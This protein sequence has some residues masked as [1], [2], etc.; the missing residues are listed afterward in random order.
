M[1]YLTSMTR[2]VRTIMHAMVKTLLQSEIVQSVLHTEDMFRML[3]YVT[4]QTQQL[5]SQLDIHMDRLVDRRFKSLDENVRLVSIAIDRLTK[6]VET[7][8]QT[9]VTVTD[10]ITASILTISEKLRTGPDFV[11]MEKLVYRMTRETTH[12]STI[13]TECHAHSKYIRDGLIDMG[14]SRV[15][16]R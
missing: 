1:S 12:L 9:M 8:N 14:R 10:R 13:L 5:P 3:V 16:D 7:T 6:D 11:P 4:Q 15:L 2:Y